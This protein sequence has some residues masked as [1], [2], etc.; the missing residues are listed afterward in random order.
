M[1][2]N[3]ANVT[4]VLTKTNTVSYTPTANYHPATKKYVDDASVTFKAFSNAFNTT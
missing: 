1:L 4:D 3:K 2:T